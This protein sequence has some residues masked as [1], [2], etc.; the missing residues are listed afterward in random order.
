M[1][2]TTDAIR[3]PTPVGRLLLF[4]LPAALA[5]YAIFQG[6]QVV[7]LPVRVEAVDANHKLASLALITTICS[8]TAVVGLVAGGAASDAT[9]SRWGRRTPWLVGMAVASAGLVIAVGALASLIGIILG[10]AILWFTLNF[11]QAALLA[12]VP[13]RVAPAN[14]ALAS[15]AFGFG[16]PA[17]AFVGVNVSAVSAP[18]AACAILAA[19]LVICV[20]AFVLLAPEGSS[21]DLEIEKGPSIGPL[22][23]LARLAASFRDRDFAFAFGARALLFLAQY[24]VTGYLLYAMQDYVGASRLPGASAEVAAGLFNTFRMLASVSFLLITGWLLQRTER[25]RVFFIAYSVL[26]AA[27][28]ALPALSATWA[29]MAG[30]AVLGGAA[31]GIFASVDLAI[32]SHVLPNRKTA[33]RDIGILAVASALPQLLAPVIGASVIEGLGYRYLFALGAVLTLAA[34]FIASRFRSV[35]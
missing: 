28:M 25:R 23:A 12:V 5:M 19:L 26:M 20:L 4:L 34:G 13:D 29:A 30:Y 21:L 9:H 27:A 31:W 33:G 24:I 16:G 3:A 17:G 1:A 8:L 14:R 7:V 2:E 10:A 22:A 18:L 15:S 11:F 35:R 6:L 32:V